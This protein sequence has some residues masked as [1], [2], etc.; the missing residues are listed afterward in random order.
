MPLPQHQQI[1]NAR[2]T[3]FVRA[4]CD[5]GSTTM[6]ASSAARAQ[7]SSADLK[8]MME[9]ARSCSDPK[10]YMKCVVGNYML[11]SNGKLGAQDC[12]QYCAPEELI[13]SASMGY[14]K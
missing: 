2:R 14:K 9:K 6:A 1:P 13:T 5:A 7:Y 10:A 4:S 3:Q 12:S 8:A 11:S